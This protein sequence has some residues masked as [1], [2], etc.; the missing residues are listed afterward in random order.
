MHIS[1]SIS[2]GGGNFVKIEKREEF[3]GRLHEKKRREK[4]EKE[5]ERKE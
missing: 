3:E 2:G 4:G 5:E 1:N